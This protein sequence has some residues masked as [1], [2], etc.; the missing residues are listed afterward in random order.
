[1]Y[2]SNSNSWL[3]GCFIAFGF[4][5]CTTFR[6]VV[7]VMLSSCTNSKSKWKST[8]SYSLSLSHCLF[9]IG[10]FLWELIVHQGTWLLLENLTHIFHLIEHGVRAI[11]SRRKFLCVLFLLI[12]CH[13]REVQSF[14]QLYA[15][16]CYL[17][18][19]NRCTRDRTLSQM[20]LVKKFILFSFF[21]SMSAKIL[22]EKSEFTWRHLWDEST[23]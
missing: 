4:I 18:M 21:P 17:G 12:Q 13:T 22:K 3:N 15:R 11:F 20:L 8:F 2:N 9:G 19:V 14:P 5:L 6:F 23:A 10:W 7:E 16:F 1:M